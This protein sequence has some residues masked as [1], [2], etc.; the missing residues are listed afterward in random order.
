MDW[1]SVCGFGEFSASWPHTGYNQSAGQRQGLTWRL[2]Q[3]RIY[4]TALI[5]F[6]RIQF[7]EVDWKTQFLTIWA[8][9]TWR[10]T[11][12]KLAKKES[13]TKAEVTVL[14]HL[15]MKVTYPCHLL[16]ASCQGRLYSRRRVCIKACIAELGIIGNHLGV[17]LAVWVGMREMGWD[18]HIIGNTEEVTIFSQK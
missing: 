17:C 14:C 2:N 11:S 16:Q 4:F 8:S 15:I 9:P 6:D 12:T 13:T 3:R 10:L 5:V 18:G 7:L 1:E